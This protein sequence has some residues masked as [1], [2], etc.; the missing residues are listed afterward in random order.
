MN[1]NFKV[2]QI[3]GLSGLLLLGF[4]LA[5]LICGFMLFPI[6]VIMT[7]WNELSVNVFGGPVI[8]YYQA[9]LLWIFLALCAY[10]I[11][12]NS[13]SVKIQGSD[14]VDQE[15]IEKIIEEN[16]NEAKKSEDKK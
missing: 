15:E 3:H 11:L 1:K 8:N 2:V 16:I 13:I 4:V 9:S 5:G 7:C 6:W 10:L 12:R 14:P